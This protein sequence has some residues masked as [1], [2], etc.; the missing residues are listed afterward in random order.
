M[1]LPLSA[2]N[3]TA[4]GKYQPGLDLLTLIQCDKILKST[5]TVYKNVQLCFCKAHMGCDYRDCRLPEGGAVIEQE[6]EKVCS[7]TVRMRPY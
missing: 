4:E 5:Y 7:L 3:P 6:V 2:N 1:N